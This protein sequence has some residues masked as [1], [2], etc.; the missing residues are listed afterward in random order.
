[1]NKKTENDSQRFTAG[2]ILK[3]Q[4]EKNIQTN[5]N[6]NKVSPRET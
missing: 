3:P 6:N 2:M 4:L 1:M 5:Y